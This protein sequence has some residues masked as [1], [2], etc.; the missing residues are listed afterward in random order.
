MTVQA[1]E[2]KMALLTPPYFDFYW[3][4]ISEELDHI[5]HVWSQWWTKEALFT[6]VLE[7]RMEVWA[8]GPKDMFTVILFTQVLNYPAS[9]V[10]QVFLAFGR[11]IDEVLPTLDAT[12]DRYASIQGCTSIEVIG[13]DGWEKKLQSVGF[14]PSSIVLS[15]PVIGG[16]V[17]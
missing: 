8:V 11:G 14:K 4:K 12:L 16:L 1:S 5:P 13:R 9:R 2:V 15:R 7:R 10:L 3:P 17:N 6:A